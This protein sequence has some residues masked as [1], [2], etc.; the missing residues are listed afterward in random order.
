MFLFNRSSSVDFKQ[1]TVD[2]Y[3]ETFSKKGSHHLVDVREP[4]EFK[5]GHVPGA[6]N[7][8]LGEVSARVSEIPT[9]KPVVLVCA[10]GNRSGMAARALAKA[11]YENVYNLQG[12]TI[13]WMRKGL[14]VAK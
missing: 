4:S 8:P 10:S 14:K 2:E 6:V 3:R 1:I 12:G 7:I 13:S 9:D 11:G 5:S